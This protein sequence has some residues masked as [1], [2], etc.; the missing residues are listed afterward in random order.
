MSRNRFLKR[1]KRIRLK[2]KR[3]IQRFAF[4]A[5][6]F[7]SLLA[8]VVWGAHNQHVRIVNIYIEGNGA[9]L[10]KDIKKRVLMSIDDKYL[11]LFPKNNIL[12]Y[13][14]SRIKED[15]LNTFKR[16]YYIK[17]NTID[18]TS[19]V[20]TVKERDPYALWCGESILNNK[21]TIVNHC[22]FMDNK[23]FVFAEAPNFSDNV[24]FTVYGLLQNTSLNTNTFGN[25]VGKRFLEEEYFTR[26][27]LFRDALFDEGIDVGYL[28]LRDND[29]V[30]LHITTGGKIVFNKKQ[31]IEKI[32][33]NL[34]SA[35]EAKEVD[36]ESIWDNLEYIDLRFDNRVL[37][38][39]SVF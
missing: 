22:F 12:I 3:I 37:F 15:I 32:F 14:K 30:E 2:E 5:V 38:K 7:F 27:M 10:D 13:T 25:S 24:Y 31:D 6:I 11:W 20:V 1:N 17:V 23:G 28:I 29:D 26:L 19:I 18:L 34:I 16:I 39:P 35:V 4:I 33:Y 21:R 9:V 36:G 8:L